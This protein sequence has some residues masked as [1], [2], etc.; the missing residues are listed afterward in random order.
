LPE[1]E[2]NRR[3]K[4]KNQHFADVPR[5]HQDEFADPNA[6]RREQQPPGSFDKRQPAADKQIEPTEHAPES[7]FEAAAP[8][9]VHDDKSQK[10]RKKR[11]RN[12]TDSNG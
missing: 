6:A 2:P 3:D 5:Q 9:A 8:T 7:V 10:D 4:Q 11:A 12:K 1:H